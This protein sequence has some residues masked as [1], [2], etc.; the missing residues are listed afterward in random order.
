MR[1]ERIHRWQW[2]LLALIIGLLIA[3]VRNYYT[4]E[5]VSGYGNSMNAQ[6]QFETAIHNRER[7]PNGELRPLF[8]KLVVFNIKE[9]NPQ[10]K[11][12]EETLKSLNPEQKKIHDSIKKSSDQAAYLREIAQTEAEKR[13]T[14]A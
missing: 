10:L 11:G 2:I 9:P 12:A 8:Y 4:G 6:A 3:A 1:V 5:D 13:R 14:Y 7:L